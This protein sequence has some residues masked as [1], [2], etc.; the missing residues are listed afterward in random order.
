MAGKRRPQYTTEERRR[1][2][3]LFADEGLSLEIIAEKLLIPISTLK[4]WSGGYGWAGKRAERETQG[5]AV[6]EMLRRWEHDLAKQFDAHKDHGS[7]DLLLKVR[8]LN[9][10]ADPR[11][12][13]LR[14]A[15]A[16]VTAMFNAERKDL[17]AE[18]EP[19][20]TQALEALD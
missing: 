8:K 18:V 6:E 7:L 16:I 9:R 12:V 15:N 3:R 20:M 5:V 1:A 19:F 17:A 13:A 4:S 14:F 10:A 2:E 11:A